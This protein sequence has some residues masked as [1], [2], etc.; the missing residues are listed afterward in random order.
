MNSAVKFCH[1]LSFI[2]ESLFLCIAKAMTMRAANTMVWY[3]YTIMF[4]Q[5]LLL[6]VLFRV[7]ARVQINLPPP[8]D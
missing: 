5:Q 7:I 3:T 8:I 1:V 6:S 4:K 2:L